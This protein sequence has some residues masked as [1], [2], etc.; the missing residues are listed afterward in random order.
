VVQRKKNTDPKKSFGWIVWRYLTGG[1]GNVH[2]SAAMQVVCLLAIST[3]CSHNQTLSKITNKITI[4]RTYFD[5][6][7][8]HDTKT[9]K[10]PRAAKGNFI[11][12]KT[13]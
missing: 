3:M 4:K 7:L 6:N 10:I 1:L 5:N 9:R 13:T 2:D 12:V 11:T 8:L